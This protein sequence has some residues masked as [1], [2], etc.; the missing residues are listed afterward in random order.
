MPD[1]FGFETPDDRLR[2]ARDLRPSNAE[3]KAGLALVLGR[4]CNKPPEAVL[5]GSINKVRLWQARREKAMKVLHGARSSVQQYE[6]AIKE[7]SSPLDAS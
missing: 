4:L 2:Y 1:L 7:M 3:T 6:S 5:S